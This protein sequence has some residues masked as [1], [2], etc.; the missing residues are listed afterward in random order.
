MKL[1]QNALAKKF[2]HNCRSLITVLYASV[3]DEYFGTRMY[4]FACFS[5]ILVPFTNL[6][7]L[8]AD[9]YRGL[10]TVDY[11]WH[12]LERNKFWQ[13]PKNILVIWYT[14]NSENTKIL[15]MWT[16]MRSF[17]MIGLLK[18]SI[19]CQKMSNLKEITQS[20]PLKYVFTVS[21][22]LILNAHTAWVV[23]F[24]ILKTIEVY[25]LRQLH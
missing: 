22:C 24:R 14:L 6:N 7:R 9:F 12:Q 19:H 2:F 11:R 18:L 20:L 1:R 5:A 16:L 25:K 13:T 17:S 3:I 8:F 4:R 21:N 10:W 15:H 23:Y